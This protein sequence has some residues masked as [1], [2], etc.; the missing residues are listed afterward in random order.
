MDRA[1]ARLRA[2]P[3]VAPAG[4]SVP[5]AVG[6]PPAGR[7]TPDVGD[8]KPEAA[9]WKEP[10]VANH[11]EST[12]W[13]PDDAWWNRAGL[14]P[15]AATEPDAT[16]P[17]E[18]HTV[19]P[20]QPAVAAWC[21]P[22]DELSSEPQ[23]AAAVRPDIASDHGVEGPA[24][25]PRLGWRAVGAALLDRLPL[26]VRQASVTPGWRAVAGLGLVVG[27][28]VL[29]SG[30]LLLRRV[31]QPVP[32]GAAPVP[33]A[34]PSTT[35]GTAATKVV[36]VHVGGKVRRPGVVRLPAGSRVEDALRAAGGA[37]P[38]VD[39]GALNLARQLA[40][41]E[42]VLVGVP[43]GAVGAAAAAGASPG[44]A[45]GA[46]GVVDLNTAT[47]ADLDAL[48]GVGPVLAQRIVDFRSQHGPYSSVDQLREVS[49]IG[50][51]KFEDLKARV[52]V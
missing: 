21:E 11:Q 35:A 42:Q 13:V 45:P 24:A 38:G 9:D 5:L 26:S 40:D 28:V 49:G 1:E 44:P 34:V 47:V 46:G 2:L 4:G 19:L 41:G 16:A 15:A 6:V 33:R 43:A 18:P 50:E 39:S 52:R 14:P 25:G 27:L 3:A 32:V 30:S 48:P 12:G 22:Y 23:V 8:R 20:T 36:V 10:E 31:P 51:R 17:I 29:V 7:G 37:L